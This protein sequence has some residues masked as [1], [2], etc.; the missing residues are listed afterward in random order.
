MTP[1]VVALALVLLAALAV[2]LTALAPAYLNYRRLNTA[3]QHQIAAEP[4]EVLTIRWQFGSTS[5]AQIQD[6]HIDKIAIAVSKAFASTT[7]HI[8]T[9]A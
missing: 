6:L 7:P 2:G 9:W 1:A 3:G 4:N 5:A 8:S